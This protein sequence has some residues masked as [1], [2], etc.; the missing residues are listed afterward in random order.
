MPS[1][2]IS[3]ADGARSDMQIEKIYEGVLL[4]DDYGLRLYRAFSV[5]SGTSV[6]S[7]ASVHS[8]TEVSQC[9]FS[10]NRSVMNIVVKGSEEG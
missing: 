8:G 5:H 6:H 7:G 1:C 2:R 9:S 4:A 10:T 3:S